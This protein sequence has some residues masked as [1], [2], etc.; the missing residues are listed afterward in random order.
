MSRY[1]HGTK[2][3]PH[4]CW[5]PHQQLDVCYVFWGPRSALTILPNS[6]MPIDA[7]RSQGDLEATVRGNGVPVEIPPTLP[8][9]PTTGLP[10]LAPGRSWERLG[11]RP[12]LAGGE[13][14]VD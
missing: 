4:F 10:L 2:G 9:S 6:P 8:G 3:P 12:R 14:S 5:L 7:R 13:A 1:Y 11:G